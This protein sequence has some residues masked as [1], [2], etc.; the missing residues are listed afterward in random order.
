VVGESSTGIGL[1]ARRSGRIR[2]EGLALAGAPSYTPSLFEQVRDLNGILWIHGTTGTLQA[3]WRRVNSLRFDTADG[4]GGFFAPF[5]LVDTRSGAIKPSHDVTSYVVPGA[6]GATGASAIPADAIG[7]VGNLTAVGY[8][9]VGFLT[10]VPSGVA[11]PNTSSV[12]FISGQYAVANAFT[13]GLGAGGAVSV[14]VGSPGPSHY[15]IDIT[16]YIQ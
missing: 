5:R 16:G 11:I 3:A 13:V 7:V 4:T 2:Q 15:I 10:I 8:S 12:N 1:Y 6:A 14:Y 9:S